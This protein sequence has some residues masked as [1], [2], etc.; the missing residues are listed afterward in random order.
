MHRISRETLLRDGREVAWAAQR[1][2]EALRQGVA[3]E[4]NA[5]RDAS[6]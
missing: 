6:G 3:A 4:L 2:S 1:V 5:G